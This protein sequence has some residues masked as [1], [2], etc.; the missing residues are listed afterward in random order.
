MATANNILITSAGRR[1]SLVKAFQ[2]ELSILD[3]MGLVICCDAQPELSAACQVADKHFQVPRL[4][5]PEYPDFLVQKCRELD[6][7][8]IIPTIDTELTLLARNRALFLA[9]GIIPIV[10]SPELIKLT[11]DKRKTH[12]L[13]NFY[14]IS[15][16]QEYDRGHFKYPMYLKPYDGSRSIDNYLLKSPD[17]LRDEHL[18]NEKMMF[19]EY[20]DHDQHD[21]YTCDLYYDK[22]HN[23]KCVVPRKRIA[24]REGEVNKGITCRNEVAKLVQN[25]L[26]ELPGAIGCLTA[27]FFM[28]KVSGKIT[29]IEINARFGGGFPLT[30][31]AGANYP[32]WLLG[33][34][35]FD[36]KVN[37]GFESWEDQLLMLRYDNEVL[38]HAYQRTT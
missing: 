10:S 23:L 2:K 28:H 36:K 35:L 25:K 33:E 6:I 26:S 21:E 22:H 37:D 12:E 19:L 8:L 18:Q 38:V 5:H 1:V 15:T 16:A 11:Q 32:G 31:L 4:D 13:F 30:Y 27:Q 34:Y 20:L 9:N 24:I 17:E 14:G 3:A 7:K 29:G